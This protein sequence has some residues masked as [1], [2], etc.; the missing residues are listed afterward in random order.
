MANR[1]L[2][3][4][5]RWHVTIIVTT[6]TLAV[7]GA[8]YTGWRFARESPPHQG[9][10]VLISID[11]LRADQLAAYGAPH[12]STP[13]IDALATE[14]VVFERAY[15]HSPQ[16][17]PSHASLLTGRLPF[18]HGVRDDGGYVMSDAVHT[19]AEQ[20]R[21]R[22]FSTGA[23]VSSFLLR[24]NTGIAR[25]FS[26]FDAEIPDSPAGEAL[27]TRDGIATFD[28]ADR[29]LRM[30]SGQR[31]FLFLEVGAD[32]ADAV[33]GRLVDELKR[34]RRYT[35]ST[36][37]L[38]ADHG[39]ASLGASLDDSSLRVPFIVKQP[40]DAGG[41]RRVLQPVQHIDVLPTI[42]DLVRG[43]MPSGLRGRSLRAI[44]DKT[45]GFVPDRP[46]YAELLAPYLRFDGY[47]VFALSSG[48]YRLVRA[49]G[50]D[51]QRLTPD[52]SEID[53][54]RIDLLH[55]TLEGLLQKGAIPP[56]VSV[57]QADEDRLGALGFLPGL[58]PALMAPAEPTI[59]A[60]EQELLTTAHRDVAVL[61][62]THRYQTALE[63]LR[64][65]AVKHPDAASV[66]YQI[67]LLLD[68]MDRPGDA[69][70]VLSALAM[71]RPDDREVAVALGYVWLRA[72]RL[73]DADAEAQRAVALA[74][75]SS[76]APSQ[77]AAHQLAARVALARNDADAVA[78]HAASAQ[79][80]DPRLPLL[81]F[82]R[83]RLLYDDGEY[84]AALASFE[85]AVRA[86]KPQAPPVADLHLFLGNT[87]ARFDR[88]ADAERE[89][90]A[91]LRAF[92]RNIGAY[93]SLATLYRASNRT[94]AAA[95]VIDD[96]VE[97]APT[98][99]GYSTAVRLLTITGNRA[100][101]ESLR[102]DARRRFR[103]DASVSRAR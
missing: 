33:V 59:D 17:L 83:G 97:T 57:A 14:G 12:S 74:D 85:E 45:S 46:I 67:A 29:W 94:E 15:T 27:T 11:G 28:A 99:E 43:P 82:F 21:N 88:Y 95:R 63:R 89:F 18:E 84:E 76:E 70:K 13:A 58:R 64:A 5:R 91:E 36:I 68:R 7:A 87:L 52:A 10:I 30:Q 66:Q 51:V 44:L 98:A 20:L 4:R 62:S 60:A 71:Q 1:S 24:S 6:F 103:G 69:A 16:T 22:G 39:D 50:E 54:E 3:A 9:P 34:T 37:I 47:P 73:D 102:A 86:L 31:Y 32:A 77:A 61:V 25:G 93:A 96:L 48:P 40:G 49:G 53:S 42:V 8:A 35:D 81:Q 41:G 101:A 38:T 23:A 56:G 100:R 80:A 90:E 19:I 72:R 65:I 79:K 78:A 75:A 92:P 2:A 55:A 26:F